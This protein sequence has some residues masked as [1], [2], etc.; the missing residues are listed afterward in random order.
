[1]KE[2]KKIQVSIVIPVY[3]KFELTKQCIDSINGAGNETSYEIIIADDGSSDETVNIENYFSNVKR[4]KT[5]K[6]LG[7]LLNIK[8][9]IP[10]SN[11]EYVFLMNNDMIPKAKFLDY[12]YKT[13]TET[14]KLGVV[15]AMMLNSDDTIQEVGGSVYCNGYTLWNHKGEKNIDLN[16]LYE[17]DYCSGC[18]ILFSKSDW[19]KVH[20]FDEIFAPAYFEDVDLCYKIKYNLNKGIVCQPKAQIYHLCSETYKE[21]AVALVERNR[22][23]FN[24]KWKS[25]I[26]KE[27]TL[28]NVKHKHFIQNIFSVVNIF[29]KSYKVL[30][31]LGFKFKIK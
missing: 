9:A 6:N 8:N 15:G 13:I 29:N 19:E 28:A 1:M 21:S 12:L 24:N 18:G 27:P 20:G 4:V 25:K 14:Q 10:Y 11:G 26:Y 31:I 5:P 23:K 3:N 17:V 22:I 2:S 7:F 16:K 30:T